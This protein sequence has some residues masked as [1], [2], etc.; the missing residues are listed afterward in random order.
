MAKIKFDHTG[1]DNPA[2]IVRMREISTALTGNPVF[3]ALAVKLPPFDTVVD[4]LETADTTYNATAQLASEQ[5]TLRD[6]ARVAAEDSARALASASEDRKSTRLN[7]SHV[8]T[9]RMPS[10]A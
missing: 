3:A 10:S 6:A 8:V 7:S 4:D 9:S 1:L 2:F 5:L